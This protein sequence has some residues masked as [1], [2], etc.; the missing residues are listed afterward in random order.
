MYKLIFIP[1]SS[2][3]DQAPALAFGAAM[4]AT[5]D[6]KAECVF[7]SKSLILL[8]GE[9]NDRVSETYIKE[10]FDASQQLAEKL[11]QEQFQAKTKQVSQ[12]FQ[13]SKE[14]LIGG[15][16][17]VWRNSFDLF[18]E[19][20]EQI[21]NECSFHDITVL[22]FDLG[23]SIFDDVI[24]GALFSAGRPIVL[25][26]SLAPDKKLEDLSIML[27]W[28]PS[29]QALRAQWYALPLLQKAKQVI[30]VNVEEEDTNSPEDMK[31]F[32]EYLSMHGVKVSPYTIR[33][34]KNG[35]VALEQYY[36]EQKADL[37]VMGAYSHS[38]LKEL[39]F[40]GFTRHFLNIR[41]CNLLLVH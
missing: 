35:A 38:R 1:L 20:V 9:Q 36:E 10:G 6:A 21:R 33:N 17:L 26:R 28:K 31:R 11:Y 7:A 23:A 2:N 8:R 39:V 12:W 29:P 34:S 27:A 14:K 15:E 19:S 3:G 22:S 16:R 24:M 4:S 5:F 18:G 25:I 37:L 32:T 41:K 13:M 30:L 40:G